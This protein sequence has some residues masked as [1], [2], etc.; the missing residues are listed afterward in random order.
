MALSWLTLTQLLAKHCFRF[1]ECLINN[2]TI[3]QI[4]TIQPTYYV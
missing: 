1:K 3:E 4:Y 2:L